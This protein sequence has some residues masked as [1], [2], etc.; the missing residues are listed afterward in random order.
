MG[1]QCVADRRPSFVDMYPVLRCQLTLLVDDDAAATR[2]NGGTTGK[3][4]E[5]DAVDDV[6]HASDVLLHV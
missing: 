2:P 3:S 5:D 1:A 6:P 4:D